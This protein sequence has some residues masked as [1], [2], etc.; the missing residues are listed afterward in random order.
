MIKIVTMDGNPRQ[1]K[2][3]VSQLQFDFHIESIGMLLLNFNCNSMRNSNLVFLI[4]Q[5]AYLT[6]Y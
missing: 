1:S 6:V 4:F 2:K 5:Y 3:L